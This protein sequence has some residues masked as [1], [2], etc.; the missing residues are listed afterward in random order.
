MFEF[1]LCFVLRILCFHQ[2]GAMNR[3]E[4]L[5]VLIGFLAQ[6][7][8][9]PAQADLLLVLGSADMRTPIEAAVLFHR[10]IVSKL[11][12]SA[13]FGKRQGEGVSLDS[14]FPEAVVY[15][16][17]MREAGVPATAILVEDESTN[18]NENIQFSIELLQQENIFPQTVIL[19]QTPLCQRRA[20]AS[21][22]NYFPQFVPNVQ[23]FSFA[24]YKVQPDQIRDRGVLSVQTALGEIERLIAYGPEGHNYIAAV[25]IPDEVMAAVE[26]LK[27]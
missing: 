18:T 12:V 8:P 7:D 27:Q 19:M 21:F 10:G 4:A 15:Y 17:T 6:R 22:D 5:E 1:I 11:L 2:G 16:E 9:L 20:R 13:G 24:A 26:F 25:E 3:T 14:L 23:C